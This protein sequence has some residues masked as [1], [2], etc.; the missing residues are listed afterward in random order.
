MNKLRLND[1]ANYMELLSV[2]QVREIIVSD[3]LSL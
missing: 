1:C 2:L 3:V